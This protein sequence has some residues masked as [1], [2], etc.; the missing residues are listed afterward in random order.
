MSYAIREPSLHATPILDLRPTQM[1]LGMAEVARK[2]QA[3]RAHHPDKL[4]EFLAY[5]MAPVVVGPGERRYLIDHHHLARAL[6]DEGVKS[7]FVVIVA[8]LRRLEPDDFWGM[9]EFHGWTHPYD[10]KGRRRGYADLPKTVDEME[11]D[12]YRSLAGELRYVGGYAKDTTP[13]SEFVWADF[14]RRRIRPKEARDDFAAALDKALALAKSDEAFYL[15]GW[16]APH[17]EPP[18]VR[19]KGGG[20]KKRAG[21]AT[22]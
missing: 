19:A 21:L 5:H 12:P 13:F 22:A 10:G 20:K 3:W 16:C 4:A 18:P 17:G 2:R 15:P 14:L 11:D 9:M 1:T 7:V 8:D 6:Y